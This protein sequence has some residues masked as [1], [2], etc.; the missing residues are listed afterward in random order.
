MPII[1]RSWGC[2]VE[3]GADGATR[4][5]DATHTLS[6]RGAR[7]SE[8]TRNLDMGISGEP[9]E[10][11]VPGSRCARPGTTSL[12][13]ADHRQGLDVIAVADL[14]LQHGVLDLEVE[15]IGRADAALGGKGAAKH[16]GAVG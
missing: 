13:L 12:R 7:V 4:F 3:D 2:I 14:A 10:V 6:F 1:G 8:R 9:S 15:T 11:E 16:R 5:P